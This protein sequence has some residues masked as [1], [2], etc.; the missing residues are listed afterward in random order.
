[1]NNSNKFK[2]IPFFVGGI[3]YSGTNN[4]VFFGL[5]KSIFRHYLYRERSAKQVSL[6]YF[7]A[8]HR[9][10]PSYSKT[11]LLESKSNS[12]FNNSC[13]YHLPS[14]IS[15]FISLISLKLIHFVLGVDVVMVLI[16]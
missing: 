16:T 14:I 9:S 7:V 10:I 13:S 8:D 2:T 11:L 3:H 4:M 6:I 5:V 1:M 12:D 15:P